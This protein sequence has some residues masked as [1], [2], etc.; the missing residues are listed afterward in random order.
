VTS[1]ISVGKLSIAWTDSSAANAAVR[2]APINFQLLGAGFAKYP[3][4]APW[5]VSIGLP[6][7]ALAYWI[8]GRRRP[9]TPP[10]SSSVAA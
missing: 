2:F 5:V 4:Y 1:L 3:L 8:V 10:A 9:T 6:G 7:F